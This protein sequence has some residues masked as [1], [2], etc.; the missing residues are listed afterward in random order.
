M[1]H[2]LISTMSHTMRA[3]TL[4][5]LRPRGFVAWMCHGQEPGGGGLIL[6]REGDG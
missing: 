5:Q 2:M 6:T 3:V 4:W 1:V